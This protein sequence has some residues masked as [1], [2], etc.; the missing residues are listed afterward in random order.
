MDSS[1]SPNKALDHFLEIF[2]SVVCSFFI[3]YDGWTEGKIKSKNNFFDS[4]SKIYTKMQI[5]HYTEFDN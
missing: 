1:P 2:C 3:L 4:K 5:I